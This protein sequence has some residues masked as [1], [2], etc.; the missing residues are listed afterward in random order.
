MATQ[1]GIE[2][3]KAK[4]WFTVHAPKFFDEVA[5]G[6]MPGN[7]EKAVMNRNIRISLDNITHNPQNAN[8]NLYLK[9]S[10]VEGDQAK[11][12]LTSMELLFSFIRT[13]VRR[14]KSISTTVVN[15]RSKDGIMMTVKP[16]VVTSQRST[17]SRI[18]GIRSEMN[19]AIEKYLQGNDA[20]TI[21]RS[22]ITGDFQQELYSKLRHVAP[23][24]KVEIKKL[25]IKQ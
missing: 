13:L 10:S 20:S 22:V 4:K 25:E 12:T 9:V 6:E 19:G 7:D 23:I 21:V 16:I 18:R 15:A 1:K 8:M 11:T 3:W 5:I 24:S 14:Y 17:A 2:N